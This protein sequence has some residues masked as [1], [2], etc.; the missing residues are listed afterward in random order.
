MSQN[1]SL[2]KQVAIDAA[3]KAAK[4]ILA[5]AHQDFLV[6][7]KDQNQ[8][9]TQADFRANRVIFETIQKNFP[10]DGWLS[11][12]SKDSTTRLSQERVWIV[13]PLDGTKEFIHQIPEFAVSIALIE[14]GQPV[15]GVILNPITSECFWAV[16]NEGAFLNEDPIKTSKEKELSQA[17][18]LASR[19]EL[20]RGE[21]D[22]HSPH[23]IVKPSGGMAF[24]LC[25]VARGNADAS[26]TLSPKNEWDFAAG[27]LIVT[28]AC[29]HVCLTN[30][31]KP[32]FNQACGPLV[33][34]LIYTNE[35][36]YQPMIDYLRA[37]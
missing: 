10:K 18:V 5:V 8:P 14:K 20:K 24:K 35:A 29:G 25:E 17:I 28:E 13:D 3:Q 9:V 6:E 4:E 34:G 31:Q 36:L 1:W 33:D 21:W 7:Y 2:E 30:Y 26:F 37:I 16:K 11:E 22:N 15:V 27:V 19:S 23:F 12:E 32:S